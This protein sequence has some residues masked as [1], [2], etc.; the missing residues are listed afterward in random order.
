M[1]DHNPGTHN[2]PPAMSGRSFLHRLSISLRPYRLQ[3]LCGTGLSLCPL[4]MSICNDLRPALFTYLQLLSIHFYAHTVHRTVISCSRPM[5]LE[6]R[7]G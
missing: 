4:G 1:H 6:C 3:S 7:G 2:S 5:R